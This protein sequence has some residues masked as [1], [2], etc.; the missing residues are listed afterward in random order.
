[1]SPR[2]GTPAD[3]VLYWHTDPLCEG[4][5]DRE[6]ADLAGVSVEYAREQ[7][8]QIDRERGYYAAWAEAERLRVETGYRGTTAELVE[9]ALALFGGALANA[10]LERARSHFRA[11]KANAATQAPTS[12][13]ERRAE[14]H[15]GG[16]RYAGAQPAYQSRGALEIRT[17]GGAKRPV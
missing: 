17:S 11:A 10:R 16:K 7:R 14:A 8:R 2:D 1:M 13:E 6:V 15:R 9:S 12:L 5:S 3:R 4:A